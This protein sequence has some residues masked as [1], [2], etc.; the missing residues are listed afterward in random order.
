MPTLT[1]LRSFLT[2]LTLGITLTAKV[3]VWIAGQGG[4]YFTTLDET[5]GQLE[6]PK[7]SHAFGAGSWLEF[8]PTLPIIY[9]SWVE[10]EAAGL[11]AFTYSQSG[12]INELDQVV[13]PLASVS[14]F[15]LN[16]SATLLAGAHW[17]GKATTLVSLNPDGTFNRLE[18]I[19]AHEGSGPHKIQSQARPHWAGFSA[20][21]S[22]LHVTD[23]GAD[24]I[25][26]FKV[27]RGDAPRL[28]LRDKTPLPPGSGPR[29]LA[30]SQDRRHALVSDEL[31]HHVS[32]FAYDE[33]QAKFTPRQHID[34]APVGL[35]EVI[36]NVSE[37][38]V[39]PSGRYVYTANR[40]HDS[41]AVFAF[42]AES[43]ELSLIEHE[44]VRGDWPR[45]FSITADGRWMPVV[46]QR[47]D[48]VVVFSINP[49]DG[50]LVYTRNRIN[51]PGPVRVLL[52]PR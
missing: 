49:D 42:D 3:P 8:H 7:L 39:H 41:I 38:L 46:C 24:E 31:S 13:I 27:H 5:S 33:S 25:W 34:A 44:P 32:V 1:S 28:S 35:N 48:S 20:D 2:F 47:S 14:H 37:I 11:K 50:T 4:L 12:K 36:N 10:S 9:S 6:P 15:G 17:G 30:Y 22:V 16:P 21:G 26:N 51:V 52:P 29:H 45:N 19:F 18:Q 40:G 43:G 23:L